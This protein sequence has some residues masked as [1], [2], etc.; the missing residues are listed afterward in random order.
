MAAGDWRPLGEVMSDYMILLVCASITALILAGV[1]LAWAGQLSAE[2]RLHK[3]CF[4]QVEKKFAKKADAEDMMRA[5]HALTGLIDRKFNE[6]DTDR[7]LDRMYR[8]TDRRRFEF[9]EQRINHVSRAT[10]QELAEA[11][12]ALG[13][14]LAAP[15]PGW[16]KATKGKRK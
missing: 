2:L 4:D 8:D 15:E 5:D 9:I 16:V 12:A 14:V 3:S 6:L 13:Y 1:A 7:K 10:S 11:M